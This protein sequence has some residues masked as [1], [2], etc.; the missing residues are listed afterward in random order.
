[1]PADGSGLSDG[2]GSELGPGSEV[3]LGVR[4][5]RLGLTD[6]VTSQSTML[7]PLVP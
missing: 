6:G 1:V 2:T 3:G 5:R 7:S 4:S